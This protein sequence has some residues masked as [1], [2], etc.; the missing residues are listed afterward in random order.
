MLREHKKQDRLLKAIREEDS[1]LERPEFMYP[2]K[3]E[4]KKDGPEGRVP[5]RVNYLRKGRSEIGTTALIAS[6]IAA[7][8]NLLVFRL[9]VESLG[10]PP[11][12]VS[13]VA[14]SALLFALFA[15][16]CALLSLLEKDRDHLFATVGISVGGMVLITWII[17]MI[18][19]RGA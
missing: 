13:A 17:I 1:I 16:A 9:M 8:L 6:V 3:R 18:M 4:K 10:K 12:S 7:A 14:A 5:R 2:E 19:G 15:V 11:L